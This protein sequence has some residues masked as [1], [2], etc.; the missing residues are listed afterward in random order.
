MSIY[1]LQ[2]LTQKSGSVFAAAIAATAQNF[3]QGRMPAVGDRQAFEDG[4]VFH[5]ARSGGTTG[6]GDILAAVPNEA[7]VP[8]TEFGVT[9]AVAPIVGEGGAVGDA[10][11]RLSDAVTGL[12]KDEYAGGYL[13]ITDATGEGYQYRIKANEASNATV[14]CLV[15]LYDELILALDNTSVGTLTNHPMDGVVTHTA[16]DYGGTAT[17]FIVGKGV[18]S[19]ADGEY[20]WVQTWGP[21]LLQAGTGTII[22]GAP[23]QAA[24]DDNGS[25]QVV[26]ST[27]NRVQVIGYGLEAGADTVWAPCFLTIMP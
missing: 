27:E 2:Q 9:D 7:N 10:K 20:F 24:E 11:V 3:K 6:V 16:A 12:T 15:T 17:Q 5:F 23:I 22:Q 13:N 14:G 18:R 8:A 26:V 21:C 4:R 1:G 25:V 19:S